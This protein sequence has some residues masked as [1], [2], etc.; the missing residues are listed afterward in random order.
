VIGRRVKDEE[1]RSKIRAQAG[2]VWTMTMGV[3]AAIW[4]HKS[5]PTHT[6]RKWTADRGRPKV[7]R[8][9][10]ARAA[11]HAGAI[12]G[13]SVDQSGSTKRMLVNGRKKGLWCQR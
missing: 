12:A 8:E 4:P 13:R 7:E 10:I 5:P 3:R 9:P 11:T 6:H 2:V 1:R